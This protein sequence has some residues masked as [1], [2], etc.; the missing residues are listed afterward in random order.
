[1]SSPAHILSD[2]L[3]E[4]GSWFSPGWPRSHE[5]PTVSASKMPGV[6]AR[7]TLLAKASPLFTSLT[8]LHICFVVIVVFVVV[9]SYADRSEVNLIVVLISL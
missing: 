2:F 1:M 6:Q 4:T 5:K 7:I 8:G 9:V 3:L